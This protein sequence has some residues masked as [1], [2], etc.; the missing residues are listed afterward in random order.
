MS[1]GWPV[2]GI[3]AGL[4]RPE[5]SECGQKSFLS[6]PTCPGIDFHLGED[7]LGPDPCFLGPWRSARPR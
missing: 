3:W 2:E 6:T 7:D 4:G 5:L 1:L